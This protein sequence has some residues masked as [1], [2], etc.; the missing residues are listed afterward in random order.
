[1][2]AALHDA[3]CD[4]DLQVGE[5]GCVEVK[6]QWLELRV[7]GDGPPWPK[8]DGPMLDPWGE[9]PPPAPQFRLRAKTGHLALPDPPA[10][11]A[12]SV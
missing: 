7:M 4:L 8:A 11:P 1:M 9:F 5:T 10:V 12:D 3:L 6:G 2:S